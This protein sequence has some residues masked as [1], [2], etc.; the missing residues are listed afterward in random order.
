MTVSSRT[1][2][3]TPGRCVLCGKDFLLE[4]SDPG[5]DATCPNCGH[6]IIESA[7]LLDEFKL[8]CERTQRFSTHKIDSSLE[9]LTVE[10]DSVEAVE[11]VMQ[12]E[13]EF[14]VSIAEDDAARIRTVGD[15]MR[16]I[17]E[18]RRRQ[19]GT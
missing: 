4:F 9:F 7:V 15:A 17:L 14:G 13:A 8:F 1:P 5:N 12:L 19:N 11:F 3:G 6:L 16:Y 10:T 2:E 18:Q